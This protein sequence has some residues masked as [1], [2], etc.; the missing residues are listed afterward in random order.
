[1]DAVFNWFVF[2]VVVIAFNTFLIFLALRKIGQH[3]SQIADRCGRVPVAVAPAQPLVV[4]TPQTD[5]TDI[6]IAIAV[7][8][9]R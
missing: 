1:M 9:G 2:S 7:A 3:L 4:A 8:A 5:D 6:A